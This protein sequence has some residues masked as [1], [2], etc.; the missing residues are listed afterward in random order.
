M[1][2]HAQTQIQLW[3]QQR[4]EFKIDMG[5]GLMVVASSKPIAGLSLTQAVVPL[6][7]VVIPAYNA[8][9]WIAKT[10]HSVLQQTYDRLEV[11]VVDDGSRDATVDI[12][13]NIA[14]TDP[15]VILL[16][17]NNA[18]VAIAR[19]RGIACASGEL[20]APIDADDLWH[21]QNLEKQVERMQRAGNA[22]GVV[23]S[24]SVDIDEQERFSGGIHAAWLEGDLYH[25]L[26]C[27]NFLGNA[28]ATLIRR[29]CLEHVGGYDSQFQAQNAQGCEDW[30]LY[31]RLAERYAFAVVPEFLVGYRKVQQSM[32]RDDARMARSHQLMLQLAK[33]RDPHIPEQYCKLSSSSFYLYL[34]QQCGLSGDGGSDR[35]GPRQSLHWLGQS[36]SAHPSPWMRPGFYSL[37]IQMA[38][39]NLGM[40]IDLRALCRVALQS[41][42]TLS[43]S[44]VIQTGLRISRNQET[45]QKRRCPH[46]CKVTDKSAPTSD[47][48]LSVQSLQASP[49]VQLKLFIGILLHRIVKK[50]TL[51]PDHSTATV[52]EA[53]KQPA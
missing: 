32:S 38:L 36:L 26:L 17:Q 24:W 53:Y 44:K 25:T 9:K 45:Q 21:P 51:K 41:T 6:V 22:V 28:S 33:H 30:D 5:L 19:N 3:I 2:D 40:N 42:F 47:W 4:R 15:R 27:H 7:S 43:I 46:E 48:M 12:V 29:A 14:A 23:Y 34:A 18:G 52:L 10:L 20:I 31:L 50:G 49:R 35:P 11:I 13:Q 16:Q 37:L 39:L 8:E 1:L